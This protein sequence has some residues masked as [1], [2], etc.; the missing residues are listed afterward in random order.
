MAMAPTRREI[1]IH[2]DA[3]AGVSR[4]AVLKLMA[5][6]LALAGAGCSRPPEETIQPYV[7]IPERMLPEQPKYYASCYTL[8]GY[9]SGVLLE[10]NLGRPTK[11]EGNPRHPASLGATDVYTQASILEL[12][13]PDRAQTVRKLGGISTWEAFLSELQIRLAG[14]HRS[15]GAGLRLLTGNIGSPT[16]QAQLQA[17]LSAYP[18]ARWVRYD[19]LDQP[20]ARSGSLLAF[21]RVVDPIYHFERANVVLALDADF[22]GTWPG[23]VRYAR[24]FAARR[25]PDAPGGMNRLYVVE[26]GLSLTGAAADHR[27]A[28]PPWQIE[29]MVW[30]LARALG[31]PVPADLP[32]EPSVAPVWLAAVVD[33]LQRQRGSALILA[34]PALP[35]NV[36]ALVHYL[37]RVLGNAGRT[38]SYIEPVVWSGTTEGDGMTA[39]VD[40]MRAGAV[41]SLIVDR[42]NPVY[43]TPAELGFRDALAHVPWSV[44]LGLY[45]DETGQQCRWQLP[46][47]HDYEQWSD[48]RSYDGSV[49]IVQPA[50]APLYGGQSAHTL[51][52]AL[53]GTPQPSP[54][55]I[56]RA[57][58]RTRGNAAAFEAFWN[59]ALQHGVIEG[60]AARLLTLN[61]AAPPQR[62][63]LPASDL[64]LLLGADPVVHDGRFANNGW[65][66]ELPRPLTRLSWD[67]ALL[68]GP[69]LAQRL[70]LASGDVVTVRHGDTRVQAPVWLQPGHADHCATL[71][72]GYGRWAAGQV[73]NGRGCNAYLLRRQATPWRLDHIELLST[74]RQH[75]FAVAQKEDLTHGRQPVRHAELSRYRADPHFATAE[76]EDK[77]PAESLYPPY[78]YNEYR[79]GM[80][81]DLNACIGCGAC[82][83]ACQAENNI[84]IVGKEQV[85]LGRAMHWIRVDRYFEGPLQRPRI[86]FQPVPCMHCENAPCE[87]VCP[88]GA[89]VH[90]SEGLNLQVYNRCIGT[91][92]CSNNCPYKVRRFNFLQYA[93]SRPPRKTDSE[94]LNALQNPEVTVRQR[95]VMEKCTYCIQRITRA[96]LEAEKQQRRLHDGEVVTA[97]QAVCPTAAITF[98]DLNDPASAVN[99]KKASPLDYALLAELNTRPRTSYLARVSNPHP[100][101]QTESPAQEHNH[102]TG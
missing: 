10:C 8:N 99:R 57:H 56:V 40:E 51:Y 88:V 47:A 41:D 43:D 9:G 27:L 101:L 5:A 70:Q 48:A 15:G 20:A 58:W 55:D 60:S 53:L 98:G 89:T 29:R 31:Q 6:S 4:R 54:Y 25:Q 73:G 63:Q 76:P 11:V 37:N 49:A 71:T 91:R 26:S 32:T 87:E 92:F 45:R 66:Q 17:L 59:G 80:A 36:H 22:L 93:P 50:I 21:G 81:I 85:S 38:V 18:Q 2:P 52:A 67:N 12:W 79:W 19:P 78:P 65:L 69:A 35:P 14:W 44:Q 84:P 1:P 95:G 90:D 75:D 83:V 94:Q 68:L 102:G 82:T 30:Q 96:R 39:L 100:W 7:H 3:D 33:D 77:V 72:L 64:S 23:G 74:G 61:A 46:A 24:D 97:C 13:D 42:C 28:L 62:L 34:G 16:L 86:S